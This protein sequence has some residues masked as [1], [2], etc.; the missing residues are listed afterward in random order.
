MYDTF[1]LESWA[2]NQILCDRYYLWL[3]SK[4]GMIHIPFEI[5]KDT[6]I[7]YETN[8]PGMYNRHKTES[9]IAD[10]EQKSK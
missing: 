6:Q 1:T 10:T 9:Q 2:D 7:I 3:L 8:Y 5:L 4:Y